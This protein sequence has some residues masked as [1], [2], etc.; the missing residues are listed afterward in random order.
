MV[1][2]VAS[3]VESSVVKAHLKY[4]KS[5]VVFEKADKR[6]GCLVVSQERPE[7]AAAAVKAIT[8]AMRNKNKIMIPDEIREM[9]ATTAKCRDP[10][11]RKVLRK[12]GLKARREFD[13][14]RRVPPHG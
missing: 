5:K 4:E 11:R 14:S 9:T 12:D 1:F 6:N 2:N 7:G 8:A 13:A 3:D 10:E